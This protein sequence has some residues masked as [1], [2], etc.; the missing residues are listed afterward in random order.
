MILKE[1]IKPKLVWISIEIRT[2]DIILIWYVFNKII[3]V[4]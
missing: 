2:V 4:V 3:G 1:A